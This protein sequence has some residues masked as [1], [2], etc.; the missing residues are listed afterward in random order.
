[1]RTWSDALSARCSVTFLRCLGFN[2]A[3]RLTHQ[4]AFWRPRWLSHA[5][6]TPAFAVIC[7]QQLLQDSVGSG[8]AQWDVSTRRA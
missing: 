8:T 7:V 2:F 3:A 5:G 6:V 4:L 1:M